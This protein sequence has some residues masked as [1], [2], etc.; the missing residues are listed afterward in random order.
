MTWTR[1]RYALRNSSG[2]SLIVPH[3]GSW[4]PED[5]MEYLNALEARPVHARTRLETTRYGLTHH[6]DINGLEGYFN[7]GV[8]ADGSLGE[9][10]IRMTK[11]GSTLS[12][13]LDTLSTAVSIALQYGVP[14]SVLCRKFI[15]MNYEPNGLTMNEELRQV[16]SLS[17]YIFRWLAQHYLSPEEFSEVTADEPSYSH[18]WVGGRNI[19]PG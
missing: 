19:L 15:G 8:Y 17:D 9:I 5:A 13:L 16:T 3:N 2:H 7:T 11:Q 1:D 6:F 12:G 4:K 14:L 18:L 10:F